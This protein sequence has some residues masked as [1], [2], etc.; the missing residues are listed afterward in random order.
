MPLFSFRDL[1]PNLPAD[2]DHWVAETAT[3]IGNVTLKRDASVWFGVTARAD[4]APILIGERSNVQENAVLHVDPGY[5]VTI[6]DDTTIG[7]AAIIHGC[8]IGDGVVV[9]MG[10]ILMNG[11]TI[12]DGSIVGAGAV[13]T[14]GK[15]FPPNSLIVG[16]PAKVLKTLDADAAARLKKAALNY[17]ENWRGMKADLR[18]L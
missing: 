3:L 16:A 14:E 10:S 7:H 13:V 17:V 2:G 18:P 15:V 12:G 9:G 6:G 4:H 5:P 11:A 1:S 8:T